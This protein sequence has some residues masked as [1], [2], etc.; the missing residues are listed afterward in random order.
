MHWQ[1]Y[2]VPVGV[3]AALL[4]FWLRPLDTYYRARLLD[5][6][7]GC[8]PA[9]AMVTQFLARYPTYM[10]ATLLIDPLIKRRDAYRNVATTHIDCIS[11]AGAVKNLKEGK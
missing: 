3:F 9:E 7:R 10:G 8:P 1:E 4:W 6:A 11:D 5:I 2:V